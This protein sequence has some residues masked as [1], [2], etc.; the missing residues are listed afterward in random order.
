MPKIKITDSCFVS[1][2]V[3]EAGTTVETDETTARELIQMGRAVSA[4]PATDTQDPVPS[5]EPDQEPAKPKKAGKG[6]A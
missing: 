3:A 6:S 5:S 4:K 2:H 1:G